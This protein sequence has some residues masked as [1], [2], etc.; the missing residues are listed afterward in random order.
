MAGRVETGRGLDEDGD[1][2]EGGGGILGY[3]RIAGREKTDNGDGDGRGEG[4]EVESVEIERVGR[5]VAN[6][7]RRSRLAAAAATRAEWTA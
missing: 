7:A 2:A 6:M 3:A 5:D 4:G 1:E